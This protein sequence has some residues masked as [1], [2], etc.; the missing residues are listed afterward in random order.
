MTK[1][2]TPASEE[3][4]TEIKSQE[5]PENVLTEDSDTGE[6]VF[7]EQVLEDAEPVEAA[8]VEEAP[9]SEE[10]TL[11][12]RLEGAISEVEKKN[13]ENRKAVD[14][15]AQLVLKSPDLIHDIH[16][17]DPVFANKVIAKNWGDSGIKTY[18]QLMEYVELESV[19][20]S[21]PDVYETKREMMEI[22]ERLAQKESKERELARQKFLS[23]KGIKDNPYDPN[24]VKL[25]EA[26]SN[27]NP[28][29]I[30][31]NYE[32][33]L[34]LAHS[35]AFSTPLSSVGVSP[36][37]TGSLDSSPASIVPKKPEMSADDMWLFNSLKKLNNT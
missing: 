30:E 2:D 36:Q 7:T 4:S 22:K 13:L 5:V 3:V 35:I 12:K 1:Q 32:K 24:L 15:Q 17:A 20:E 10:D 27:I 14:I 11:K 23:A 34:E 21:N 18:K 25:E 16:E 37:S 8:E 26:M 29:I 6:D 31:D 33:A 9:A 19:K 28:S